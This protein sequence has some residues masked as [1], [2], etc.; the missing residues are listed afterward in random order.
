[1]AGVPAILQHHP[2][3]QQSEAKGDKLINLHMT[4]PDQLAEIG[5]IGWFTPRSVELEWKLT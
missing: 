5:D 4:D 1:M 2:D 3:T